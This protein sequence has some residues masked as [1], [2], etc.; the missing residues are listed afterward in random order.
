M[1]VLTPAQYDLVLA[2]IQAG[3]NGLTKD[4]LATNRNH[5]A[6]PEHLHNTQ[7][8]KRESLVRG[9]PAPGKNPGRRGLHYRI[10]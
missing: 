4:Q 5:G 1:P 9:P 3:P 7:G 2:L 8:Q 6:R 10:L